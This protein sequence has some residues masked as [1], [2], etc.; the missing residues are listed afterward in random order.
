VLMANLPQPGVERAKA[1]LIIHLS[2][3]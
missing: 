1:D 3:P 2:K